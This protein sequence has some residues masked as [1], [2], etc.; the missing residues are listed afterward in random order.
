MFGINSYVPLFAQ[1]V[2]GGSA[3]DAGLIVLPMSVSWPLASIL[4]GRIMI[5][6]GYYVSA[7]TGALMLVVGSALLLPADID[8]STVFLLAS[9]GVVGLGMGFMMPSLIISVQ[10]S[11]EWNNRGVATATTQFFRTIGGRTG[12]WRSRRL[13]CSIRLSS[14][15]QPR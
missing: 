14:A 11:V 5:K 1:G 6:R 2:N 7:I 10:N 13:G 12:L 4:A 8:S 9:G 3:M 15:K